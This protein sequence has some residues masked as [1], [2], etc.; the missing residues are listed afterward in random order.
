MEWFQDGTKLLVSGNAKTGEGGRAIWLISTVTGSLRVLADD[1]WGAALSPDNSV[2]AYRNRKQ[3]E[4]W[5]MGP[6]GEGPRKF[7]AAPEGQMFERLSWSPR[8]RRLAYIKSALGLE[9]VVIE[10]VAAGG[11]EPVPMLDDQRIID[12]GWA[13]DGR[14]LVSLAEASPNE[15]DSNLWEFRPD[16]E[17]GKRIAEPRRITNWARFA[18]R[19]ISLSRDGKR[20]AFAS[21]RGTSDVYLGELNA[22][23]TQLTAERRLTMDERIDW[24]GGWTPD[25]KT[26][27]ISDRNGSLDVFRQGVDGQ[28]AE[29]LAAGPEDKRS[30]QMSPDGQWVLYLAWPKSGCCVTD[31]L[32]RLMRVRPGG[33][34][35]EP[36]FSVR[37]YPGSAQIPRLRFAL[38][39]RGNPDFRCPMKPGAP[40]ILG[41]MDGKVLVFTRFDPVNGKIGEIARYQ[42]QVDQVGWDLSPD[43]QLIVVAPY[44]RTRALMTLIPVDGGS[45]RE[46]L[47]KDWTS[48]YSVAWGKGGESLVLAIFTSRY[49]HLLHISMD[50]AVQVVRRTTRSMERPVVSPDGR[51]LMFAQRTDDSNI[52][53]IE[54][55]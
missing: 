48:I 41:E 20:M 9:R 6:N 25:G 35:P 49:C 18:F 26:L 36:V 22:A 12:F 31:P 37:G 13:P 14:I 3:N 24:P 7:L 5:L 32:G 1:A 45:R 55:F 28:P 33:G 42:S 17:S 39:A 54:R 34:A 16:E 15:Y 4:V 19:D 10:S 29:V 40:C 38:S 44:E 46:I 50:G 30:P 53:V 21:R 23:G 8:G 27:F 52:W 47:A 2:I 11:G 43:G 51:Y